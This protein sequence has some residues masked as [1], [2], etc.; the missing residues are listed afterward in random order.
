MERREGEFFFWRGMRK[1]LS[2]IKSGGHPSLNHAPQNIPTN[3]CCEQ[4]IGKQQIFFTAI[5]LDAN[6]DNIHTVGYANNAQG[7]LDPRKPELG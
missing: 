7:V 3:E 1:G 4:P 6:N 2:S 5:S